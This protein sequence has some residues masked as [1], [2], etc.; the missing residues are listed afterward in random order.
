MYI[1][2]LLRCVARVKVRRGLHLRG[3]R[4]HV[5][6]ATRVVAWAPQVLLPLAVY[7]QM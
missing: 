7:L 1:R 5:A 3:V 4:C 2:S 6:S